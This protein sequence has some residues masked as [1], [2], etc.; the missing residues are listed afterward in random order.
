MLIPM[1]SMLRMLRGLYT[2]LLPIPMLKIKLMLSLAPAEQF[3]K[4]ARDTGI[5]GNDL[6]RY[7]TV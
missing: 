1:R 5:R 6:I 3:E 7:A 4:E 2:Y